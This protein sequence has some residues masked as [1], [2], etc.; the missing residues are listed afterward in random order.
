MAN[1][2]GGQYI[3]A[4]DEQVNQYIYANTCLSGGL[5]KTYGQLK[6]KYVLQDC[7]SYYTSPYIQ[8]V[9]TAKNIQYEYLPTRS[10]DLDPLI[11]QF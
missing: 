3:V 8:D 7:A 4:Q 6:R 5:Y 1:G 10:P 11:I 9:L 2:V